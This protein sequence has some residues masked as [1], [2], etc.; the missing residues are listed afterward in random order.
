[1]RMILKGKLASAVICIA[2]VAFLGFGCAS[3]SVISKANKGM[4]D[5][6]KA[7][8]DAKAAG[9]EGLPEYQAAEELIAKA[10]AMMTEGNHEAAQYYL[11]EASFRAIEA[12]GKAESQAYERQ[13]DIE[14]EE[15]RLRWL[16]AAK[17]N[18]GLVDVFFA[19]D[20]SSISPD[21]KTTLNNNSKIIKDSSDKFQAV[22]I[23]GYCDVRGTEEYNLALGQRRADSAKNY[24][25]GLGVPPELV[26]A[27]SKGETEQFA[28]GASESSYD[29]NRRAHFVPA[30]QSP[31]L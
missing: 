28:S 20:Q 16:E 9:A 7:L 14:A 21:S 10:R 30:V 18:Y 1:M 31:G 6:E 19:F 3:K 27:V 12:K 25:I 23:E 2:L 24:L 4:A 22:I 8:Q 17:S 29:Q 5:A 15:E 26:Q 13:A 11:E